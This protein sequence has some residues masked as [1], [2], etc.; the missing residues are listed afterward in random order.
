MRFRLGKSRRIIGIGLD[1]LPYTFA[2]KLIYEGMMPNLHRL[3]ERGGMRQIKSV[4]PPVSGV[5]WSAFQTGKHPADF[6]VFGFADLKPDFELYLPNYGDL[7]CETIWERLSKAGKKFAALG[8]PMTYPAPAVKGFLVSGFPTPALDERAVS[9]RGVLEQLQ[10]MKYEVDIDP[11]IAAESPERFKADLKRVTEARLNAARTLLKQQEWDFF[12][13][14]VMDTDRLHHFLWKAQKEGSGED[15]AYFWDFYKKMDGFLGD[16]VFICG[17]DAKIM[18][19][20]DHGFCELKW[21]FQVNRW[22]K[23]N[24]YLDYENEPDKGYKAIKDGSRAV[25]LVPGR[26]YILREGK[27][28][29]GVVTEKEYEPLRKELM[30]KLRA[31][32]HPETNEVVCKQVMKKEE[33]FSGPYADAAPDILIDPCNGYDLKA[34]LE[35]GPLFEKGPRSGM[36]TYDD[37]MLLVGRDL[38]SIADA[39]DIAEVGRRVA[40][41]L[42]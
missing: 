16:V 10:G 27:W 31:I 20:S 21:E 12:F 37:A 1:G 30:D 5:A 42:L 41:Y 11:T 26:I 13:L 14:H 18:V 6:G 4:Y 40:K 9:N 15:S 8:V 25:S 33:V 3:A 34:K 7:K 23:T 19:C 2:E 35:A 36:H 24:G 17:G 32:T 22:L 38:S 28:Q 29:R 39:K